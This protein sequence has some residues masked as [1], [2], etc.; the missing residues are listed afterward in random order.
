MIRAV[1]V[2]VQKTAGCSISATFPGIVYY[3]KHARIERVRKSYLSDRTV[4]GLPW[5]AL[6][7]FIFVR[8][9]WDRWLEL[10]AHQFGNYDPSGFAR[11]IARQSV[12][13]WDFDEFDFVGQFENLARDVASVGDAIGSPDPVLPHRHPM[14][15]QRSADWRTYYDAATRDAVAELGAW[16]IDRFGYTFDDC[17]QRAA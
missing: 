7:K 3:G 1:F 2:H 4:T 8:N 12:P 14:Q 17:A 16:E 10:Y 15:V 6:F 5:A 9:P 13:E 11:Y